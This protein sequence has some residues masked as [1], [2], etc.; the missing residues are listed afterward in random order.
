[1]TITEKIETLPEHHEKRELDSLSLNQ[2]SLF[3]SPQIPFIKSDAEKK[4]VKKLNWTLLPM[5]WVI[6]F[7]QFADKSALSVAAVLGILEDTKTDNDQYGFLGS[8]FYIGFIIFQIPN[9]YLIQ[10]LPTS[11]Y[12]GSLIICWGISTIGTAFCQTYA[13]L[14]ACRFLLGIFE[15]ATQP[16]LILLLNSLYRRSEQSACLGFF[17]MSNGLGTLFA[18]VVT[19]GIVKTLNGA[20]GIEAWR[21]I[22]L[23][24]GILTVCVGIVTFIFLVD[25]P[26]SK[27]LRLTEEEKKI[28]E[29]RTQDNAVVKEKQ[30]KLHHYWEALREPR[31]YLTLIGAFGSSLPNSGLITFSTPFVATLGFNSLSAI[32]LQLPSAAISVFFIFLSVYIHRKTERL[33]IPIVITGAISMISFLLLIVLPHTAIK[34]LGYY[35]S[36]AF[37]STYAI[38]ITMVAN[39]VSGYSKKVFY[40]SSMM[41]AVTLGNFTGPLVMLH[42]E[43]PVYQSG[44]IIFLAGLL[45][46]VLSSLISFYLMYRVNK[47]R[48]ANGITK[49]DAHLDLTDREDPNFIYKL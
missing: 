37:A 14:L 10:R 17:C 22:Y 43:A 13:H 9:S 36:W 1:M 2:E 39:N 28:I 45:A 35:L 32:L 31:Y 11:K 8:I 7:I 24:F 25:S 29:E 46:T 33:S 30:V 49:T 15:A 40:N 27:W 12:L 21:W 23:I 41:I 42:H 18:V 3:S 19:F 6:V 20:H 34:L 26:Y 4:F 47:K 44:M 38:L 48:L 16:C 5:I